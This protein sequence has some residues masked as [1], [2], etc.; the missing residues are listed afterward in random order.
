MK[1]YVGLVLPNDKFTIL[2]TEQYNNKIVKYKSWIVNGNGYA[3]TKIDGKY[4][5]MHNILF[6]HKPN[7]SIDKLTVDHKNRKRWDNRMRNL[8]IATLEIQAKNKDIRSNNISGTNGVRFNGGMCSEGCWTASWVENGIEKTKSFSV[9]LYGYEVAK[10]KAIEYRKM[11]ERE[12]PKYREALCLDD[13]SDSFSIGDDMYKHPDILIIKQKPKNKNLSSGHKGIFYIPETNGRK[14][15]W[16]AS[17][18]KNGIRKTK[19]FT[20]WH[21]EDK[22][23]ILEKAIYFKNKKDMKYGKKKK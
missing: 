16:L 1:K 9:A 18:Q 17:Y 15:R 20:I 4:V 5:K 8:R 3:C 21:D 19:S 7:E 23:N 10:E 2:D 22:E 12:I 11:I 13:D 14:A 6:D